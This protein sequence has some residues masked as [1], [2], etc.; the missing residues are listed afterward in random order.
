MNINEIKEII[1]LVDEAK[2]QEVEIEQSNVKI[3]LKRHA[4]IA[5]PQVIYQQQ[6]ATPAPVNQS[7]PPAPVD[8]PAPAQ[9]AAAPVEASNTIAIKS[10]MT[11]TFYASSSPDN[12]PYV[13]LGQEV[14]SG[15][16]VCIIE[17]MKLFNE[18]ESEVAG[19]IEKIL[20]K[21]GEPVEL[22]QPLFLLKP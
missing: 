18:I 22:D 8:T 19:T 15:D 1:K 21:D 3:K 6:A 5:Q 17:A 13:N 2:L 4:D 11:G 14:K 7:A 10:P 16:A 9:K 12:P 20:V